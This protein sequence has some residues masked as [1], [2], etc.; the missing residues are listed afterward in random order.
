MLGVLSAISKNKIVSIIEVIFFII[1]AIPDF[2]LAI[3]LILIFSIKLNLFPSSGIVSLNHDELN[4]FSQFLDYLKHLFLPALSLS[5][6]SIIFLARFTKNSIVGILEHSHII[7]LKVR[8]IDT[9]NIKL[10]HILKNSVFPFI[11][12]LTFIIPGLFG[13]SIII[14]TI[15]GYPG[16]GNMLYKAI[17]HRDFPLLIGV[18]FVNVVVIYFSIFIT[19]IMYEVFKAGELNEKGD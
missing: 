3:F 15:F 12:L 18:A 16:I 2:I 10:K 5:I 6:A 9:F 8:G 4:S 1:Y 13:G 17:I 11:S 7:A 14:E 19:D